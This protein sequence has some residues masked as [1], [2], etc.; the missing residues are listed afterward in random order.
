MPFLLLT[1]RPETGQD[2]GVFNLLKFDRISKKERKKER[3]LMRIYSVT[4]CAK[5][6]CIPSRGP[7]VP[8]YATVYGAMVQS[9]I[10]LLSFKMKT[11]S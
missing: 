3:K 4:E 11:N 8:S 9:V 10:C 6:R 7:R 2:S 1:L 5:S